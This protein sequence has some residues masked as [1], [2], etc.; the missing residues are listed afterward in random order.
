M[1]ALAASF[2]KRPD[3]SSSDRVVADLETV[4]IALNSALTE[5][6]TIARDLRLPEIQELSPADTARRVIRDFERLTGKTVDAEFVDLPAAAPLPVKIA[7]YR[8]LQEALANSYRHAE[9]SRQTVRIIA[10]SDQICLEII[11]DGSGFVTHQTARH[12]ALGLAG[13]R[14][15]VEMLGGDFELQS[16]PTRGTRVRACLPLTIPEVN[17]G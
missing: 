4:E 17:D 9:G 2:P 6:R 1:E 5:L 7:V 14:E 13:M 12:D 15:R 8:V 3:G 10:E 16:E 11:D